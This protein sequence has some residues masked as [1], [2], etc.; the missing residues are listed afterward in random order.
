MQPLWTSP[1]FFL[2]M[3]LLLCMMQIEFR[4]LIRGTFSYVLRRYFGFEGQSLEITI[5]CVGHVLHQEE[6]ADIMNCSISSLP[7][8]YL[9]LPLGA[10]FKSTAIWDGVIEKMERKF[11]SWKKIYLSRGGCLTLIKSIVIPHI[12]RY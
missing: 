4:S 7:L 9:G 5:S 10:S 3:T 12:L 8:K 11:A 6:L 2:Q 1:I